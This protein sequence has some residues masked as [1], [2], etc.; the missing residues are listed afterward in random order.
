M[1]YTHNLHSRTKSIIILGKVLQRRRLSMYSEE[2]LSELDGYKRIVEKKGIA[3]YRSD[4]FDGA[5]LNSEGNTF[6]R[7]NWI[8]P[9]EE[10]SSLLSYVFIVRPD[11][12]I[13]KPVGSSVIE[14]TPTCQKDPYFVSLS[15]SNPELLRNT[16]A[17][18]GGYTHDFVNF[19]L[20]RVES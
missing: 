14:L 16:C 17:A 8:Y 5:D 2:A 11:L 13:I 7:Y 18:F 1:I 20:D 6:N 9:S 10:L 15:Q 12:N 19:L 4:I 3:D